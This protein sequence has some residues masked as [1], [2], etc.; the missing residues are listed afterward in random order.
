MQENRQER[1]QTAIKTEME[2]SENSPYHFSPLYLLSKFEYCPLIFRSRQMRDL[3]GHDYKVT[4]A[5][6]AI[7]DK[8]MQ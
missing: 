8:I 4:R 1:Q 3:T 6:H 5:S 2:R 7:D